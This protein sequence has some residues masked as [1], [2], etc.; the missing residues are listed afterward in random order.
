MIRNRENPK[1]L[2]G[3]KWAAQKE[4]ERFVRVEFAFE[5]K[6]F[7]D[8]M[9]FAELKEQFLGRMVEAWNS[10]IYILNQI[11]KNIQTEAMIG[12]SKLSRELE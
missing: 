2:A 5:F 10:H 9:D 6:G 8:L 1:D 3:N 4:I 7:K 12:N 11:S